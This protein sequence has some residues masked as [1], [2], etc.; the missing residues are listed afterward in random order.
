V[1]RGA[2]RERAGAEIT[3]GDRAGKARADQD[4]PG[5]GVAVMISARDEVC[6]DLLLTCRRGRLRMRTPT[7][8]AIP[9]SAVC[10][11]AST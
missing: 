10:A 6:R 9:A 1:S 3:A 8:A 11:D 2:T 4:R 7:R 5:G